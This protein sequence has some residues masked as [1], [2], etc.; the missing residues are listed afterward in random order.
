MSQTEPMRLRRVF[1]SLYYDYVLQKCLNHHKTS[2]LFSSA[3]YHVQ[4]ASNDII[5]LIT[6]M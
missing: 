4:M 1:S 3:Y 6:V 2:Q 5:H